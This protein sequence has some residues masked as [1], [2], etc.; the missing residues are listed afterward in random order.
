MLL[1]RL[2]SNSFISHSTAAILH[3]IP[4]PLSLER[5]SDIHVTVPAP[6]R[7]PHAT[8]IH[9]HASSVVRISSLH[10]ARVSSPAATW[11]D[12]ATVLDYRA[13]TAAGDFVIYHRSPLPSLE[14]LAALT[15]LSQNRRGRRARARAFLLL[16]GRSESPPES[17]LRVI[18]QE[19]GFVV[20]R[21]NHVVVDQ[22]GEF[23]ARTDFYLDEIGVVLEY[24]GDYH[25][26]TVG[27]WRSDMSR[28]ARIELTRV[29][30][31][32]LNADDL[33]DEEDL[34]ARIHALAALRWRSELSPTS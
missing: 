2:P 25:R 30:V 22:F 3:G 12:L 11:L 26:T 20:S 16:D 28:R 33:R 19:R 14:Q 7:A 17:V 5:Q 24:M 13:L 18:L 29:R 10:G 9:G 1:A 23:V 21:I 6:H 15:E 31:M 27:Q 8:G 34:V 32:E 4:V